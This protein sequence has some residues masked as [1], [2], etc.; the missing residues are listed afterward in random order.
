MPHVVKDNKKKKTELCGGKANDTD[1][2]P[3][4]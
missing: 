2:L 3:V 4:H 1:C